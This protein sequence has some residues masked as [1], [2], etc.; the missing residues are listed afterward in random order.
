MED[1]VHCLYQIAKTILNALFIH[2]IEGLVAGFVGSFQGIGCLHVSA[3]QAWCGGFED[4]YFRVS[5]Q[6]F[7]IDNEIP[8]GNFYVVI[9]R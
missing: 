1:A 8:E 7:P 3:G 9:N 6:G 5:Q 4:I 2:F